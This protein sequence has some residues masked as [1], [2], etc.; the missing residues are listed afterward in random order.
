ML[1]SDAIGTAPHTLLS[2]GQGCAV[3]NANVEWRPG[4]GIRET[5]QGKNTRG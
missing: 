5:K 4:V 1:P 2:Y 3:V